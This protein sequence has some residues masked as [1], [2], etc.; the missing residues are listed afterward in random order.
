[1][2]FLGT[3]LLQLGDVGKQFLLERDESSDSLMAA[4]AAATNNWPK[5][6][7][8]E[9]SD[10][11]PER[12]S[13]RNGNPGIQADPDSDPA[14]AISAEQFVATALTGSPICDFFS[15][16]CQL[17]DEIARLR[18]RRFHRLHSLTETAFIKT[19]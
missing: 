12:G 9:D 1:M 2:I 6:P 16:R 10:T 7:S 8:S 17:S 18:G 5:A 19:V 15:T 14:W 3:L 4:A 13:D 11:P